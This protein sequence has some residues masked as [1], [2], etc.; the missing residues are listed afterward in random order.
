VPRPDRIV[1]DQQH[2]ADILAAHPAV[3]QHQRV[4]TP[5]Q[6]MLDRPVPSQLGQVLLFL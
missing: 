3:Q 4:R 5:G 2:P 1:V 6:T